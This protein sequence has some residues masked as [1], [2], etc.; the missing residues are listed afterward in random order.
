MPTRNLSSIFA[1]TFEK[2]EEGKAGGVYLR[3]GS[4]QFL[5]PFIIIVRS[6]AFGPFVRTATTNERT[7]V[8]IGERRNAKTVLSDGDCLSNKITRNIIVLSFE[9]S[10]RK[11]LGWRPLTSRCKRSRTD[12][13]LNGLT[14]SLPR[15]QFD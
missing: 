12:L 1:T 11:P 10:P 7:R 14:F 9:D 3:S 13:A 5:L 4:R 6:R 2:K 8:T 15:L